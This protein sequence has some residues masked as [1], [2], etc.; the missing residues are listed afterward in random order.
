MKIMFSPPAQKE[1]QS[2]GTFCTD[3]L[4]GRQNSDADL[5]DLH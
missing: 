5:E 3:L 1:L 4:Q 2:I